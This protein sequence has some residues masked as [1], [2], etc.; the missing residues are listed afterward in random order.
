M[1]SATGNSCY[2]LAKKFSTCSISEELTL[3]GVFEF[4]RASTC[5]CVVADDRIIMLASSGTRFLTI[6]NL[7]EVFKRGTKHESN[8]GR[9]FFPNISIVYCPNNIDHVYELILSF[10]IKSRTSVESLATCAIP[11]IVPVNSRIADVLFLPD[12]C[13]SNLAAT[14]S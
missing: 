3:N 7:L 2:N 1:D 6:A 5:F 10:F 8:I 11:D 9:K 12:K 14:Y 4:I 13:S